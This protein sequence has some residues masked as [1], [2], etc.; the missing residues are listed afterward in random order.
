MQAKNRTTRGHTK[1]QPISGILDKL[2]VSLGLSR[3]YNG[4]RIVSQWPEIVGE[5]YAP[6]S[7]AIRF[8]EGV[9]YVAVEDASWRQMMGMD[10]EKILQIIRGYPYGRV[11]KELRLVC[12]EKR[13]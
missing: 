3:N 2:V 10:T 1:P 11:V 4:W 6:K 7:R 13:M 12:G 9:L 8:H 5:H